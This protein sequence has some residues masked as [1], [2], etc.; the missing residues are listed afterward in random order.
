MRDPPLYPG[1]HVAQA[2]DIGQALRRVGAGGAQ[3]DVV[4]LVGAQNVVDQIAADRH[5]AAVLP[6]ARIVALDQPGDHRN[7]AEGAAQ[8]R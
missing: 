7:V 4:G 2:A 1:Q 6:L 3:E 5:L 8:H